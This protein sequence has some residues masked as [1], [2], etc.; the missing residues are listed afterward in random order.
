M[1]R[2]GMS[3]I[4]FFSFRATNSNPAK[5]FLF[6]SERLPQ[7]WW[8][9]YLLSSCHIYHMCHQPIHL[10]REL[11]LCERITRGWADLKRDSRVKS[12][13][14]ICRRQCRH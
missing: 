6:F 9:F 12:P 4:G 11:I 14:L 8:I 10:S 7:P 2:I 13:T 5:D 3:H 1:H